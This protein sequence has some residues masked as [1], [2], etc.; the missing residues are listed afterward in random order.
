MLNICLFLPCYYFHFDHAWV[1][2]LQWYNV[3]SFFLPCEKDLFLFLTFTGGRLSV[4]HFIHFSIAWGNGRVKGSAQL[5]GTCAIC[6]FFECLDSVLSLKSFSKALHQLAV[7]QSKE[8]AI[9]LC[10]ATPVKECWPW[11]DLNLITLTE[12]RQRQISYD[13]TYML[14][15][16]KMIQMYILTKQK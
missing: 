11:M 3:E 1:I 12:V 9:Q 10:L 4:L 6:I 2:I 16:K 13:I 15:L 7:F 8:T 14:S 5:R